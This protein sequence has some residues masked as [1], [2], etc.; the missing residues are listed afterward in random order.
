MKIGKHFH[1]RYKEEFWSGFQ[2]VKKRK[3]EIS[4]LSKQ[5]RWLKKILRPI[6]TKKSPAK[7]YF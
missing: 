1:V 2:M 4:V 5:F 6:N 3:Q 7:L